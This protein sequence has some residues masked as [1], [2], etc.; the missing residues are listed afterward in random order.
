V[1]TCQLFFAKKIFRLS[2]INPQRRKFLL[3]KR[4]LGKGVCGSEM[5][6]TTLGLQLSQAVFQQIQQLFASVSKKNLKT[7]IADIKQVGVCGL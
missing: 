7:A 1:R 4:I 2:G 3:Q 6:D 5:E